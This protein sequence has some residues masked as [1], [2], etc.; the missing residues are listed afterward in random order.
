MDELFRGTAFARQKSGKLP[1]S[2]LVKMKR[3]ISFTRHA[4][5]GQFSPEVFAGGISRGTKFLMICILFILHNRANAMDWV[6]ECECEIEWLISA[7]SQISRPAT[8][9]RRTILGE[10]PSDV[11]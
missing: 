9:S 4:D 8:G 5:A 6:V 7:V 2:Y 11:L 10:P 3:Q 1:T